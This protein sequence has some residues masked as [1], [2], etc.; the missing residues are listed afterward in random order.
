ML[1]E[2]RLVVERIALGH[3][4]LAGWR[5]SHFG[6]SPGIGLARAAKTHTPEI[7]A[8]RTKPSFHDICGSFD[9]KGGWQINPAFRNVASVSSQFVAEC[10]RRTKSSHSSA[11]VSACCK[12]W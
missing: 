9:S 11:A 4:P 6:G 7:V 3:E 2:S 1:L 12:N 5:H 10:G 8:S